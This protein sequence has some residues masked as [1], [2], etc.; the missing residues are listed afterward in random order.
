MEAIE[1]SLNQIT[2]K[3]S[4]AK[5]LNGG[6]DRLEKEV[7]QIKINQEK[8]SFESAAQK[9]SF[10]RVEE[11]LDKIFDPED[12]VYSKFVKTE[13]MLESL[14]F[15]VNSLVTTDVQLK[16]QL[17]V[18][19]HKTLDNSQKLFD[20]KKIA[21]EDNEDLRKSIN[22]SNGLWWLVAM[23]GTGLLGALGKLIWD[24]FLQ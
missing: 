7:N 15:K 9:K 6:F 5:V 23:A 20:L 24:V 18:V 22:I 4:G 12:G 8:L 11:K 2:T 16:A 1:D 10:E 3:L 17:N 14:N 21:G 13:N 19:E